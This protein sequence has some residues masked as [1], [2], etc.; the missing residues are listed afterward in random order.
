MS[1]RPFLPLLLALAPAVSAQGTVHVVDVAGGAGSHHTSIADAIDAAADG[2]VVLIRAGDYEEDLVLDDLGL[3]VVADTFATGGD[4]LVKS[5]TVTNLAAG[6]NVTVRGLTIEGYQSLSGT[7]PV[8]LTDNLGTIWIEEMP[9]ADSVISIDAGFYIE[10]C[11]SVVLSQVDVQGMFRWIGTEPTLDSVRSNLHVFDSRIGGLAPGLGDPAPAGIRVNGGLLTVSG[12]E[13]VGDQGEE[14]QGSHGSCGTGGQGGPAIQEL[15]GAAVVVQ[16]ATL[17]GGPAG[18]GCPPGE[19]GE[20]V[21]LATGTL[22]MLASTERTH[23]ASSPVRD[24]EAVVVSIAGQPGD[25][26]WVF[27]TPVPST[28]VLKPFYDGVALVAPPLTRV[29][30]GTL[31]ASGT[32]VLTAPVGDLGPSV[33]SVVVYTQALFLDATS[34][35]L[36]ASEPTAVT[37]V[38]AAF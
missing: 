11:A 3:H 10:D 24:D 2:D 30:L 7:S 21:T 9:V 27:A 5:L 29:G 13:I 22:E 37:L 28:G 16:D 23:R 25:M 17:T 34:G 38:D 18:P 31:A 26:V 15:G 4:V 19:V 12:S 1:F 33:Q 8:S 32:L 36:V 20:A 14:G 35:R 6:K